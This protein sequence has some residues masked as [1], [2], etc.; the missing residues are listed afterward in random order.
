LNEGENEMARAKVVHS[1]D[2]CTIIFEGNKR[3][4]EPLYGIVKFPGGHVEVSRCTDD[5]Y[6]AHIE[7]EDPSYIVDGRIDRTDRVQAVS[8]LED[9]DKVKHIAV[10]VDSRKEKTK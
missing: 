4:P 1:E 8:D 10:R 2:A 5:S 6:W 9:P 3:S 7:I